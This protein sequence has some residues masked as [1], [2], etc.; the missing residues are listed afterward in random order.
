VWLVLSTL[1]VS[2][3]VAISLFLLSAFGHGIVMSFLHRQSSRHFLVYWCAARYCDH[4]T[5]SQRGHATFAF[6]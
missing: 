4:T 2:G 5:V 3:G 6:T 1:M